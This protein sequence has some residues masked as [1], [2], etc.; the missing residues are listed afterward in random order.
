MRFRCSISRPGSVFF[1]VCMAAG[2]RSVVVVS[3]GICAVE[4]SEMLKASDKK[5]RLA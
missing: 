4:V 1:G 3:C 2:T 5:F